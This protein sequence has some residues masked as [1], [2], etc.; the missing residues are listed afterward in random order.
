MSSPNVYPPYQGPIQPGDL[1]PGVLPAAVAPHPLAGDVGEIKANTDKLVIGMGAGIIATSEVAGQVDK[2]N[3]LLGELH[4][5]VRDTESAVT[6]GTSTLSGEIDSVGTKVESGFTDLGSR[7][8]TGFSSLGGKVDAVGSRV[9]AGASYVGSKVDALGGRVDAG[10]SHVGSKID[11]LHDLIDERIPKP[12]PPMTSADYFNAHLGVQAELDNRD[13]RFQASKDA[14]AAGHPTPVDGFSLP[15]AAEKYSQH[16]RQGIFRAIARILGRSPFLRS[17]SPSQLP[18]MDA[19]RRGRGSLPPGATV[20]AARDYSFNTSPSV[21]NASRR[22]RHHTKAREAK[23]GNIADL[24][25][26]DLQG[27]I[28]RAL[29]FGNRLSDADISQVKR[30]GIDLSALTPAQRRSLGL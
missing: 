15:P 29:T 19:R 4:T 21:G 11:D 5:A 14:R 13:A 30:S 28:G 27:T 26:G 23:D 22:S 24:A 1:P 20:D 7:V 18:W 8:D 9:D 10:A 3:A 2:G 17:I 25:E 16:E 6:T 12:K